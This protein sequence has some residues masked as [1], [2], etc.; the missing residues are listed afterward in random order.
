MKKQTTIVEFS[1]S[2]YLFKIGLLIAAAGVTSYTLFYLFQEMQKA[3]TKRAAK[4]ERKKYEQEE[5]EEMKS[6]PDETKSFTEEKAHTT[7]PNTSFFSSASQ[8]NDTA[9]KNFLADESAQSN[10]QKKLQVVSS[11]L[12]THEG[13]GQPGEDDDHDMIVVSTGKPASYTPRQ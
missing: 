4:A 10:S 1:L 7:S 3:E 5:A 11:D 2:S 6:F 12:F 13:T 9:S 8:A